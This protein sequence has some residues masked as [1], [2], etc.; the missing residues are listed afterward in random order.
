MTEKLFFKYLKNPKYYEE[1]PFLSI[2]EDLC[3][4]LREDLISILV[5]VSA[6]NGERKDNKFSKSFGKFPNVE[7][8]IQK[9]GRFRERKEYPVTMD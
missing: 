8:S 4:T 9:P 7:L 3:K 1:V 6:S 2:A 5:I